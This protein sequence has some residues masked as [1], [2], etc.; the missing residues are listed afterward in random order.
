M[1]S[2]IQIAA[3]ISII[4]IG[5]TALP[6]IYAFAD[7]HE[8]SRDYWAGRH[9]HHQ[10]RDH[11]AVLEAVRDGEIKPL[12]EILVEVKK[13]LPGEVTGVNVEYKHG[14]W[15]YEFRVVDPGGRL[16]DIYVDARSGEIRKTKE[17]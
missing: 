16:Y 4:S 15:L 17:K 9:D 8:S 12:S 6:P 7:S 1:I 11:D 3:L 5:L 2:R 14:F 13:K 10:S